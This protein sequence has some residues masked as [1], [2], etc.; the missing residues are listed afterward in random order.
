MVS[1]G[2]CGQWQEDKVCIVIWV[3]VGF[4]YFMLLIFGRFAI[5]ANTLYP[6]APEAHKI[7]IKRDLEVF[8]F[9]AGSNYSDW[10]SSAHLGT[11]FYRSWLGS[12]ATSDEAWPDDVD[13]FGY[14]EFLMRAFILP[15]ADFRLAELLI[16]AIPVSPDGFNR[17]PDNHVAK[18]EGGYPA[19][20]VNSGSTY[21]LTVG[22][23]PDADAGNFGLPC[24]PILIMPDEAVAPASGVVVA[25]ARNLW[26]NAVQPFIMT[27]REWL[28][29]TADAPVR[30][31]DRE[32]DHP[33][34][35]LVPVVEPAQDQGNDLF[36]HH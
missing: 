3:W 4:A 36:F 27:T 30:V 8:K 18:E 2:D 19:V 17:L 32:V 13:A 31:E 7:V 10:L 16:V 20:L 26:S 34:P 22:P 15:M 9:K 35:R 12:T 21:P 11:K 29:C 6:T 14:G 5:N 25:A 28:D 33:W 24:L 23:R 1:F